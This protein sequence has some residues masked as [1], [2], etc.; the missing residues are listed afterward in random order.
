MKRVGT[1]S[2]WVVIVPLIYFLAAPFPAILFFFLL[3]LLD[4]MGLLDG[5]ESRQP[6]NR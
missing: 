1:I 2:G 6:D 5:G 4:G 3:L